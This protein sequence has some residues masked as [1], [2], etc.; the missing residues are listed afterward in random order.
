MAR[1]TEAKDV[2]IPVGDGTVSGLLL[3]PPKARA[4]Y[5]VAHGAGAGMT[6]P[7]LTSI[8]TLLSE[9]GIATLR[10]QFPYMERKSRRPDSP[11]VATG[12]VRSVLVFAHTLAHGLP[13]FAG[14][15]SFGSRMTSTAES[16]EHLPDV[17]GL[18]FLGFP[19]H[20]PGAPASARADHLSEVR[21]P[22][23]FLQGTRDEFAELNLLKP[24]VKS[25]GRRATLHLIDGG[26]HSFRVPT[27][28][29][30]KNADVMA[31]LADTIAAWIDGVLASARKD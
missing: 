31:E 18:I 17:R 21:I 5:V 22:M 6:H 26:N 13:L 27:T 16:Q 15:K 11:A 9:R 24:L 14:G 28:T 1:R 10:Y 23:L 2:T 25:L 20:P 8:A 7:F 19:L 3:T 29:G 12:A 4:L 30:R